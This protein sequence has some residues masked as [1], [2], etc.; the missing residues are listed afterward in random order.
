M[1][2]LIPNWRK[3][4]LLP[5]APVCLLYRNAQRRGLITYSPLR[6]CGRYI[7]INKDTGSTVHSWIKEPELVNLSRIALCRGVVFRG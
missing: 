1:G 5:K 2:D 7:Q 3:H 6:G 4:S